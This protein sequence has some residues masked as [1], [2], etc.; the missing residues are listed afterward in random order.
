M[1]YDRNDAWTATYFQNFLGKVVDFKTKIP[2][3]KRW[4]LTFSRVW[5]CLGLVKLF[6]DRHIEIFNMKFSSQKQRFY[7]KIRNMLEI[8]LDTSLFSRMSCR[9]KLFLV[10]KLIYNVIMSI[11]RMKHRFFKKKDSKLW[12]KKMSQLSSCF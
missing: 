5:G 7:R 9:R 2:A 3:E 12:K 1:W 8:C 6:V 10:I 4:F 11:R